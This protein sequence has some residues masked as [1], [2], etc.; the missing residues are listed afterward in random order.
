MNFLIVDADAAFVDGVRTRLAGL[1]HAVEAAEN[2]T[3][4]WMILA[5]FKDRFD[6]ILLDLELPDIGGIDLL[7]RLR[8]SA[9]HGGTPVLVCTR[10]NRREVAA[11]AIGLGIAHYLIKPS[12]EEAICQKLLVIAQAEKC[13]F[14][15]RAQGIAC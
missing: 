7:R 6:V 9:K 13:A 12:Q 1:H 15:A 8:S 2:G 5:R 14:E 3:D 10:E 11:H 4:A